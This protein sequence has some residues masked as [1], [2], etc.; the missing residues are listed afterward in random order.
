MSVRTDVV[1]L[2]V[3]V[4][5]DKAQNELNQLRKKS[6][7]LNAEMKALHKNT[8]EYK[9]KAAEL[10]VVDTQMASLRKQIGLTALSQKELT[11]ELKRLQQLKNITTPQSKEFHELQN[12]INAVNKRL[13]EVKNGVFGFGASMHKVKAEI[14][15]FGMLA[16]SYLGFEFITSQFKQIITG[17]GKLSDQLADLQRVAGFTASEAQNLNNSLRGLDT[18][19]SGES[20]RQIAIIAGKLG[21]AKDDILGFTK[22]VDMLV[23]SLGDELGDAD[24]ITTQLG[25]ILNVFD[26][27]VNGKNIT[28]LGNAVVELANAGVASGSFITDFTQRVAGIAKAS[29]LSLGATVGLA[30][31]F[32]ELGLRSESSST[33]LQKLLS[34]IATDTPKAAKIAGMPIA[35]FNK[36]FAEAPQ[37]ALIK[38][39][40]GL[41]KNKQSFS[42]IATSFKDAGEEGARVIATLQAIGQRGE[43]LSEKIALGT[44]AIKENSA[45]TEAYRLKNE[46]LGATLDKIGKRLSAMF[47]SSGFVKGLTSILTGFG[48]LIGAVK[49]SD[50]AL[51]QFQ[52]QAEKVNKL[53]TKMLPLLDRYDELKRKTTLSKDEQVE[54]NK[55]IQ[56]IASTIPSAITQFNEYGKAIGIS[57]E[58]AR[59][60]IRT[61]QL[62]LKEKNKEAIR[63][64]QQ[65]LSNLEKQKKEQQN[66][67]NTNKKQLEILQQSKKALKDR[68][69]EDPGGKIDKEIEMWSNGML[70]I[71]ASLQAIEERMTG[72]KGWIAE[73]NG[74]SFAKALETETPSSTTDTFTAT[75]LGE[76][77]IKKQNAAFEKLKAL[78]DKI[79]ANREELEAAGMNA[80]DRE[81]RRIHKK[82]ADLLIEAIGHAA[83]IV[84]IKKLEQQEILQYTEAHNSKLEEE[85]Y[86]LAVERKR[87]WLETQAALKK[88]LSDAMASHELAAE[89]EIEIEQRKATQK[90]ANDAEAK[91]E[92]RKQDQENYRIAI[93]AL[94]DF[95]GA[96][97]NLLMAASD[98]ATTRENA[99]LN[100]YLDA[101]EKKKKSLD[102]LLNGKRIS[103]SKYDQEMAKL[104]K[105]AA[106]RKYDLELKQF[107]RQQSMAYTNAIMNAAQGISAIWAQWGA[108]PI[109]AGILTGIAAIATG[110][111][112]A[113]IASQKPPTARKGLV[114][115]GPSHEEG[116]I[117]MVDNRT[118]N[119]LAEIEGGE[120]V[121]VLSKSTYGNN[122]GLIDSLLYSSQH[123]NGASVM[124]NWATR[125]P[126]LNSNIIPMMEKGGVWS[127]NSGAGG[128]SSGNVEQLLAGLNNHMQQ[129]VTYMAYMPSKLKA[130]VVLQD[131][132]DANTMMDTIK[133]ESGLQQTK[134]IAA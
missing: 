61:Q 90:I 56:I 28:S 107:K 34:T 65:E 76:S 70:K 53:E 69:F 82:Y 133:R 122:R 134:Q 54:L 114:V 129:M 81:L 18:R 71:S 92:Q 94:N 3:N 103:Q 95:L 41:V 36:L 88:A 74:D 13:Y 9:N 20:L 89:T 110:I 83:E 96:T 29:N 24:Q 11:S 67:L 116:G 59:D 15:Q 60:F 79:I 6:A 14:K 27:E 118:G 113:T 91:V 64:R 97:Q 104:D 55:A 100:A 109:V 38:Y 43:F 62:I 4:G 93:S 31:G 50:T 49:S 120:P 128:N 17:A 57:T 45:I 1:N 21:V 125:S 72:V 52:Q 47:T 105:E 111:Q 26:G 112:I 85:E 32:E 42:E 127:M 7:D 16:L 87:I 78:R 68:G 131:I 101:N 22:A 123:R 30:A 33:A 5:G 102:K 75:G 37:Q 98:L 80:D 86:Y 132:N 126:S 66:F 19:T 58:R 12:Q 63:D 121:M 99:E 117:N 39:A 115:G 51:E 8:T 25:K 44:N 106:A 130:E 124:P 35:E 46:N 23:V 84:E 77:E 10:K 119:T 2:I 108:F 48:E 73:L 40:Q